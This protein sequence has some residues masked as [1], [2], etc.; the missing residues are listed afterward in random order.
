MRETEFVRG[1]MGH[2][3][4]RWNPKQ[5]NPEAFAV[6]LDLLRER[7]AYVR[8][9]AMATLPYFA[10]LPKKAF[11]AVVDLLKE[12]EPGVR[13]AAIRLLPSFT[14]LPEFGVVLEPH[15]PV[16]LTSV[17]GLGP[18]SI[19]AGRVLARILPAGRTAL[20]A[21]LPRLLD[22][23]HGPSHTTGTGMEAFWILNSFRPEG[24][25]ALAAALR[26]ADL[27]LRQRYLGWFLGGDDSLHL[28]SDMLKDK[29]PSAREAT[30]KGLRVRAFWGL[31]GLAP[32][33]AERLL[34]LLREAL[35]DED[36][37]VRAAAAE[38]IEVLTHPPAHIVPG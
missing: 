35:K 27:K 3:P 16:L 25:S 4:W 8:C 7:S 29:D 1:D 19:D 6:V 2:M 34:A 21:A 36:P 33:E 28:L 20:V 18:E 26:S 13:Q 14:D 31:E 10:P 30:L 12:Q 24:R 5:G 9:T 38:T 32:R 37:G 23:L 11:P 17:D 15:I 22:S